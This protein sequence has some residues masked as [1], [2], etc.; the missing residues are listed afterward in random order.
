MADVIDLNQRKAERQRERRKAE[1]VALSLDHAVQELI[2]VMSELEE[3]NEVGNAYASTARHI[4]AIQAKTKDNKK[5]FDAAL[6]KVLLERAEQ[7]RLAR[8][9]ADEKRE[10]EKLRRRQRRQVPKAQAPER[11]S[12]KFESP[13]PAP[14]AEV[15]H[16][17]QAVDYARLLFGPD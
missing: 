15:T 3:H 13:N 6:L 5:K 4:L 10:A 7:L 9:R 17:K 1:I 12:P 16:K 8:I 14:S 11:S 2:C